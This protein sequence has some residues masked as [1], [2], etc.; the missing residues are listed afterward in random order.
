MKNQNYSIV[1]TNLLLSL[2]GDIKICKIGLFESTARMEIK[3]L[4]EMITHN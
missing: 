4:P 2:L 3:K 1:D